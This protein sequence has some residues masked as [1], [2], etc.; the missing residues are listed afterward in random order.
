MPIL[1]KGKFRDM[2]EFTFDQDQEVEDTDELVQE[3]K[4]QVAQESLAEKAEK[5]KAKYKVRKVYVITVQ[6]EAGDSKAE[7]QAWIRRPDLKE[8]SMFTTM[9]AK[10]EVILG[11]K[12]V[13][14]TCF[15][16]GDR[17]IVDDDDIFLGA[18]NQL[19]E[20]MNVRSASIAKF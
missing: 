10:N 4:A 5:I 15:L 16:E 2:T 3:L 12:T 6:G 8:F 20:L 13:L 1:W 11:G 17:E 19:E 18:V 9:V 14:N 7:Y